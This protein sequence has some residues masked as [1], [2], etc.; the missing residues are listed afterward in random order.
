MTRVVVGPF[1]RV[2]GDLE[3][4]LEVEGGVVRSAE[5]SSPLFRGFE[6]ILAGKVPLDA[7]VIVP[8]VCGICSVAHSAAAARALAAAM[9]VRPPENGRVAS[10]LV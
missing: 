8:R 7:L 6:Q 4:A 3:V 1:N 9:R 2:E 5:V 10:N